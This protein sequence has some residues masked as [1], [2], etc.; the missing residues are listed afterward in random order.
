MGCSMPKETP[1][2]DSAIE[3][4]RALVAL[5][6]KH[7]TVRQYARSAGL[8]EPMLPLLEKRARELVARA[9]RSAPA[10]KP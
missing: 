8:I 2:G 6:D 4:L 1:R 9:D 10:V 5:L 3:V 7:P